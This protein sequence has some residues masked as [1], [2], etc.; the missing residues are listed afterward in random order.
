MLVD[1]QLCYE[2]GTERRLLLIIGTLLY[3]SILQQLQ[4]QQQQ[5]QQLPYSCCILSYCKCRH[6][7]LT[8]AGYCCVHVLYS[9]SILPTILSMPQIAR[10]TLQRAAT[11]YIAHAD[12]QSSSSHIGQNLML[13]P[14]TH[15]LVGIVFSPQLNVL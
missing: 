10:S 13:L 15:E 9:T 11:T 3:H 7:S 2:L 8:L 5:R 4:Q 14:S 6:K 12:L 1:S